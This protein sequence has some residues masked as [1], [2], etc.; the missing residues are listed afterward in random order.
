MAVSLAVC[1]VIEEV[2]VVGATANE[3]A[4]HQRDVGLT[5]GDAGIVLALLVGDVVDD[6]GEMYGVA[7]GFD[8]N[9]VPG[10]LELEGTV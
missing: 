1:W 4:G 7:A 2:V 10:T 3:D 9:F 6:D 5:P 8:T